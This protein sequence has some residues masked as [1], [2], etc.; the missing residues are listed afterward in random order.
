M[1]QYVSEHI[2]FEIAPDDAANFVMELSGCLRELSEYFY[3]HE[4]MMQN[5]DEMLL[6]LWN[7][8]PQGFWWLNFL[9]PSLHPR[10][11]IGYEHYFF[12]IVT[13]PNKEKY[14]PMNL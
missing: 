11:I 2:Y 1:F 7:H 10:Q 9:L 3:I 13:N 8:K 14:I 5:L 12:T 6:L 4:M